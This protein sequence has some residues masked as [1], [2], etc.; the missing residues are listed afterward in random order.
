MPPNA[1]VAKADE[2]FVSE[3]IAVEQM[4]PVETP[5]RCPTWNKEYDP[6]SCVSY[7]KFVLKIPQ[8]TVLG[9]ARDMK[10]NLKK[11]KVGSIILLNEGSGHAG[12]VINFTDTTITFEESNYVRGEKSVRT[13]NLDN[14]LIR[15][16]LV[17]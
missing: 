1:L 4:S 13:L 17:L 12:A 5:K 10:P 9:N 14:K 11:P 8:G 15:G 7:I 3:Q 6:C 16:Y 2:P